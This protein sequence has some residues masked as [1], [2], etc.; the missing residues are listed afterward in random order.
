MKG[1]NQQKDLGFFLCGL[2]VL[3]LGMVAEFLAG[4]F[5]SGPMMHWLYDNGIFLG[6]LILLFIAAMYLIRRGVLGWWRSR[7]DT[8]VYGIA[9][10]LC[11]VGTLQTLLG[12]QIGHPYT[13]LL[14]TNPVLLIFLWTFVLPPMNPAT[15]GSLAIL[16][17]SIASLNKLFPPKMERIPEQLQPKSSSSASTWRL[18]IK[19]AR[20]DVWLG[21]LLLVILAFILL[22]SPPLSAPPHLPLYEPITWFRFTFALLSATFLNSFIFIQN[23]LGDLDTD[24]LHKEKSQLPIAAGRISYRFAFFTAIGLLTLAIILAFAVSIIFFLVLVIIVIFGFLYSGPPLRLKAKPFADLFI[25]GLAFGSMAII[26][27]WIIHSAIP[28]LPVILLIGSGLFYAGTH[29]I[30]T[31]SDYEADKKA[32]INTTAVW[33]GRTAAIRLGL[34]LI[35]FGLLL[36][37]ITVGYYTHLFWYGLLKYKTVFLFTFCGIPFFSLLEVY[38]QKQSQK[39]ANIEILQR[40]G[41]KV[42]YLLF[43]ILLIYCLLYVFIFYPTYYPSYEF[44]W[45]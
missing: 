26:T 3:I 7:Y 44:P 40:R 34:V 9:A 13:F 39:E 30:H 1:A 35:A 20:V 17:A 6:L 45:S 28:P 38:R 15:T 36:L 16:L 4:A 33:I 19:L 11:F 27:S 25:I 32:G 31:A 23:Q 12:F 5:I 2:M 21:S 18:L 42:I 10:V 14:A 29:G 41:R 24:R 43:L 37:Y 22:G 8:L